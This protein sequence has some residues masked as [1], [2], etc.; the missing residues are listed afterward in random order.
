MIDRLIALTC[1]FTRAKLSRLLKIFGSC[2]N[3][4]PLAVPGGL[5]VIIMLLYGIYDGFKYLLVTSQRI[6]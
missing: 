3:S 6:F 4:F 5:E 1:N 2:T